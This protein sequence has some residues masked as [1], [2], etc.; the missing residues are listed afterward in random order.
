MR[1][2]TALTLSVLTALAAG[3]AARADELPADLPDYSYAGYHCGEADLPAAD[4]TAS[5]LDFGAV[6]D[7][8]L[9]DTAAFAKAL[10]DAAGQVILVPA[11]QYL[12]SGRLHIDSADTVLRGEDG[13]VLHFTKSLTDLDPK[14]TS[15][16][17]GTSTSSYS[18]S[19][20]LITLGGDSFVSGP[21]LSIADS[22]KLG[23]SVITLDNAGSLAI[24]DRLLLDAR[25]GGKRS[26]ADYVYRGELRKADN[27][28]NNI[29]LSQVVGIMAVDGNRVTLDRPLRFDLR[30]EWMTVRKFTPAVTESG[31]EHLTIEF[32]ATLYRGHF[33][34]V[35]W[36]GIAIGNAADCWVRD[37]TIVNCDSGIFVR[38]HFNTL[39][40]LTLRSDR[41][42]DRRNHTG[43]HGITMGGSDNLLTGFRYDQ[44]FIHDVT[45]TAGSV[46]NVIERGSAIDL[47]MDHHKWGPYMNLWTELD[48]G[49]GTRL[50]KSGGG[51]G[52][53]RNVG[54]GGTYWNI[55]GGQGGQTP[56]NNFG[57]AGLWFVGVDGVSSEKARDGWTVLEGT[58]KVANLYRHQLEKRLETKRADP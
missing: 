44:R 48:A 52:R 40:N 58:P 25:D 23:D 18:W 9:D 38:G 50:F 8:D 49:R 16:S 5:V 3:H 36:N 4:A 21:K 32:A 33:T 22:P 51:A 55:T 7:D 54:W 56:G 27:D 2:H 12:L 6:P 42:P 1:H 20:G 35:G 11:G 15:N 14:P 10:D 26:L 45:L 39:Q 29:R 34:E 57:P 24:G 30:P 28:I 47:S 13:T 17:G 37:V 46:G 53:G 43:H 19:G 41:E 31:I